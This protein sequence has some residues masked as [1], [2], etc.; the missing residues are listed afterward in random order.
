[1]CLLPC[2]LC[3][4]VLH[5]FLLIKNWNGFSPFGL[6]ALEIVTLSCKTL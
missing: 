6:S 3:L 5:Q 2:A 1:L 4:A